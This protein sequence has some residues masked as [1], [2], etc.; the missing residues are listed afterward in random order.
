M[1]SVW[2]MSSLRSSVKLFEDSQHG[3]L[4]GQCSPRD[5]PFSKVAVLGQVRYAAHL[6]PGNLVVQGDLCS[7]SAFHVFAKPVIALLEFARP[8]SG[9]AAGRQRDEGALMYRC[10]KG[11]ERPT[12][13]IE[14]R[15]RCGK[16]IVHLDR[17]DPYQG[18]ADVLRAFESCRRHHS[19]IAADLFGR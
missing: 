10:R 14:Q 8:L 2:F 11:S 17:T 16:G 3:P 7:S 12:G 9:A 4:R 5:V 15:L 13:P 18:N 19:L 6:E 1:V